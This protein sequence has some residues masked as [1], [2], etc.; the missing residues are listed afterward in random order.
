MKKVY[1]WMLGL[2][3][4]SVVT[5][6]IFL[7]LAPDTIPVHYNAA[8]EIDRWGS[9]YE[10]LIFPLLS[11][12]M[13]IFM[14]L[15]GRHE[16][17]KGDTANETVVL[18]VGIW[19]LVLFNAIWIF[20]FWK[21]LAETDLQGGGD[22]SLKGI[23]LLLSASFLPLGNRMPKAT[24]NSLYGLRTK[25]SMAD[26]VCWQKSQRLGGYSMMAAGILGIVMVSM[27]PASWAAFVLVGLLLTV[28]AIDTV[29]TYM[30]WKKEQEKSTA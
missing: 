30:I 24:R 25:W 10:F 1:K 29:G 4:L 5:L 15:V 18:G 9:K 7:T 13:G 16:G 3:L 17:Q 22:L 2:M 6:G 8:G 20:F 26:D 14:A 19:V 11:A 23:F 27:A 12:V 28:A 21:S